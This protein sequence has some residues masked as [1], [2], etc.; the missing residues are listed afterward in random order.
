MQAKGGT[1]MQSAA[2]NGAGLAERPTAPLVRMEGIRRRF[3]A[4]LANDGIDLTLEPG[5]IHALVG[6]NGAG[7]STL[8]KILFGLLRADAGC[9]VVDG[10]PVA[11]SSP[12]QALRLGIGMIHQHF[13]LVP[14]MTVLENVVLGFPGSR[15]VRPLQRARLEAR[16]RNLFAQYGFDLDP[17]RKVEELGVGERQ[18]VEIARLL[19]HGA[20]LL[21]CDEPTAVLAPPEVEVLLGILRRLRDEGRTVVFITHKLG[22]V[23]EVA[24]CVTVLRRGRVVGTARQG[25]F[26]R[27]RLVHWIMGENGVAAASEGAAPCAREHRRRDERIA[28]E[29]R[30]LDLRDRSGRRLLSGISF[31]LHRAEILGVA[32]V[33]GNGQRELA[34]VISGRRGFSSGELYVAGVRVAVGERIPPRLRPGFI[35]EDRS[36]EGLIG[37]LPLWENLLLGAHGQLP[38]ERRLWYAHRDARSWARLLLERFHIEPPDPNLFPEALSGGNR[39]KLLCARELESGGTLLVAAQ[40]TRGIDLASTRFLH[41]LLREFRD[42]GGSVLL[43]SADLDEILALADRVVVLFRGGLSEPLLCEEASLE[44][45]GRAMVGLASA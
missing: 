5:T 12:A 30:D 27:D 1:P 43:I 19:F 26:D 23:L 2:D 34:E 8:M 22:E 7:K 20:R 16:L 33:Q 44:R 32:G 17:H 40:P 15:G 39:Q 42:L 14:A 18:R 29:V 3:G 10:H 28:Y 13:M 9:I 4:S 21:I 31:T 25:E 35:P 45:L 38:F 11:L 24:D 41:D 6:E 36:T 37:D